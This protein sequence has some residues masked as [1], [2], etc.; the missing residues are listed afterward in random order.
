MSASTEIVELDD[1]VLSRRH[2]T[3]ALRRCKRCAWKGP[4]FLKRCRRCPTILGERYDRDILIVVPDLGRGVLP[5]HVLPIAELELELSGPPYH[6]DLLRTEARVLLGRLLAALPEAAVLRTL[7]CGVLV[8]LLPAGSLAGSATMAARGRAGLDGSA[9]LGWRAGLAAV[10]LVDGSAPWSA[11]VVEHAA[12]LA[13]AA[14]PGQALAGYGTARLLDHEWQFIG[15]GLLARRQEDAIDAA[16]AL[17][18]H[19]QSAPS[20]SALAPDHRPR[21]VG[22][23]RQMA[24][25]DR[26]LT[27]R[28]MARVAG[29]R[30][31]LRLEAA[32]RSCCAFGSVVTWA[33][34]CA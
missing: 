16:A 18:G 20:P 30:L 26:E 34:S 24:V 32:S 29:A 25:L 23:Q 1:T 7:P 19:E 10:G 9:C 22:R 33:R 21:L 12:R 2:D 14:Q 13:R 28:A 4:A 6:L 11:A 31:S 15:T 3:I 27:G 17:V 8:A 5:A